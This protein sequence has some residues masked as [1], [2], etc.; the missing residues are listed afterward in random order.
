MDPNL[1][2]LQQQAKS[3]AGDVANLTAGAPGLLQDLKANLTSIFSK[4]I[5]NPLGG[6]GTLGEARGQ[7]LADF[8]STPARARAEFLPTNLPM[9]EGSNLNL[10]PTQQNA[11]T[12]SRRSAAL[13]PLAG[14]NQ[15]ITG[16]FGNVP[17]IVGEAGDVFQSQ[18]QAGELRA[19]SAQ[20]AF[21]NAL[22]L[23]RD[24]EARRQFDVQESRLGRDSGGGLSEALLQILSQSGILGG[25]DGR[26]GLESFEELTSLNLPSTGTLG[27]P[28]LTTEAS[29]G[30]QFNPP[31]NQR[32]PSSGL[33]AGGFGGSP[34]GSLLGRLGL[35]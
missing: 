20:Q 22:S 30:L 11:I 21:Q 6:S 9:I 34:L 23:A 28:G 1:T 13:A 19:G 17:G 2:Q 31:T 35:R 29:P 12:T 25:Q 18:V 32:P 10:S 27:V 7:A 4:N 3:A 8:L 16:L 5:A 26:P 33:L 15:I 24:E 14:L